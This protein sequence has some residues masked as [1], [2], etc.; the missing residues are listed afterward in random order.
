MDAT[1]S[2]ALL[3]LEGRLSQSGDSCDAEGRSSGEGGSSGNSRAPSPQAAAERAAAAFVGAVAGNLATTMPAR[4][5]PAVQRPPSPPQQRGASPPLETIPDSPPS[6]PVAP[7]RRPSPP[8]VAP[9][10]R[11]SARRGSAPAAPWAMAGG[12]NPTVA[13]F[14]V[15]RR[16]GSVRYGAD[17]TP[18][19][20]P[21]AVGDAV[22][23]AGGE[24]P[25]TGRGAAS[26]GGAVSAPGGRVGV[27]RASQPAPSTRR[28]PLPAPAMRRGSRRWAHDTLVMLCTQCAGRPWQ[29]AAGSGR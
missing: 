10:P 6:H 9:R 26:Q 17:G 2:S 4:F 5:P 25:P 24:L 28:Q 1:C 15:A 21:P 11:R 27:R 18:V 7:P 14:S 3:P 22:S 16:S 23:A 19:L 12:L 29:Q 8:V 13:A 20:V